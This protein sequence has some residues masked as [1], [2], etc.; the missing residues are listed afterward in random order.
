M[1][2]PASRMRRARCGPCSFILKWRIQSRA[3]SCCGT[4][5]SISADAK[6]DWTPEHF[7][8]THGGEAF[9]K[10]VGRDRSCD[11]R[12]ERAAWIRVWLRC[13]WRARSAE[14]LTCIFVNNGVLRKDEFA[15]V[16]KKMR[17]DLGHL[18]VVA[19]DASSER[20][21]SKLKPA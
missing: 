7:I 5:R 11:L 6:Q 12:P 4:S 9:A 15:K 2:L 17:E 3:W 20:F 8:A 1:R 19:V 14:R 10:Q 16:Q 13:W 18:N 21:L